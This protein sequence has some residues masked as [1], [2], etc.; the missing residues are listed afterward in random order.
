MSFATDLPGGHA[1][2]GALGR[3]HLNRLRFRYF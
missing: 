1:A 2:A 3:H